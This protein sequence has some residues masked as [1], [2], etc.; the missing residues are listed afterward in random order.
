MGAGSSSPVDWF[1]ASSDAP[2]VAS[3]RV[4]QRRSNVAND[5]SQKARVTS[6]AVNAKIFNMEVVIMSNLTL[7][8]R[9]KS[10]SSLIVASLDPQILTVVP[11]MPNLVKAAE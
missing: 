10:L 4:A 8:L 9:L 2:E 1:C 5:P 11:G 3:G 6:F 7:I